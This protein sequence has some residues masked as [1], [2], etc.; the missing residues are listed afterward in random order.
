MQSN[1]SGFQGLVKPGWL[2]GGWGVQ[3]VGDTSGKQAPPG[4]A[5]KLGLWVLVSTVSDSSE[6]IRGLCYS[7]RF[8]LKWFLKISNE[9]N[10]RGR[11]T[12]SFNFDQKK[13]KS[14]M[15]IPLNLP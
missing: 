15:Q 13:Y 8:L 5:V 9:T 1:R 11:N 3:R 2:S 12:N 4:S 7:G 14:K 10:E 6:L